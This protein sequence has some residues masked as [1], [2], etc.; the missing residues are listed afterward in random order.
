M[1]WKNIV[2]GTAMGMVETVPGV[3]SSTI[4]ML[5]GVYGQIITAINYLTSK[6]WKLG[7]MFLIPVGIGMGIGFIISIRMVKFF[8][9]HYTMY[10]H[11][12]FMGLIIG[13]IPFVWREGY[14]RGEKYSYKVRHYTIMI[15]SFL[16]VMSLNL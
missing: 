11:Y 9:G 15:L 1:N 8:L 2:K 13:M 7:L 3:S 14:I 5:L 10:T 6:K 16:F 4:A 12:F